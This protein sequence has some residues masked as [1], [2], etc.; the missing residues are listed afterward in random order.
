MAEAMAIAPQCVAAAELPVLGEDIP[1]RT[2][3]HRDLARLRALHGRMT[4]LID[5]LRGFLRSVDNGDNSEK[6]EELSDAADDL[7]SDKTDTKPNLESPSRREK[8]FENTAPSPSR[9]IED[10]DASTGLEKLRNGQIIAAM[11]EEWR[12]MLEGQGRFTWRG[13]CHIAESRLRELDVG[14]HAWRRLTAILGRQGAS[15]ALM[16]LDANRAHPTKPVRNV[17]GAVFRFAQIAAERGLH[18]DAMILGIL[19]RKA[20]RE[21]FA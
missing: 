14:L 12:F 8:E 10:I 5:T 15:V 2:P 7:V 4:A 13:F 21:E 1:D 9:T 11:P 18:L 3:R 20:R 16:A 17:G 19:A 6:P